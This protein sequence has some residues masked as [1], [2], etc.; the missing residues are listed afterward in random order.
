MLKVKTNQELKFSI[1]IFI[2]VWCFVFAAP[3]RAATEADSDSDGLSDKLETA[4]GTD[5]N[6][7][8]SDGDSYKDGEEVTN[9]YNPLK[10]SRDR[11]VKRRVEVDLSKQTL[12]YYFNDVKIGTMAVSTGRLNATTPVGEYKF[13]RKVPVKTYRTVTG[14]SYPN[15]KWNLL[16]EAKV[17]LYLHGAYW[18]NDFGIKP[19]SGG[20]VNLSVK[21]AEKM[22]KFLDVGDAIKIYGKTPRVTLAV[23]KN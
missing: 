8:D 19:R 18:H 4:L 10:G 17:G 12:Y 23:K 14:G 20:C 15:A 2:L 11:N 9:G 13:L 6:N 1:A 5:L 3:V 21:N 22:Y 7:P 16:F